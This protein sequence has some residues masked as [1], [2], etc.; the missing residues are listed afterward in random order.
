[1]K[2][3]VALVSVISLLA[4]LRAE[5]AYALS[6]TL[7]DAVTT[8][9]LAADSP[10][11]VVQVGGSGLCEVQIWS[12]AG[13][14]NTTVTIYSSIAATGTGPGTS[15]DAPTIL[16]QVFN[17]TTN[18]PDNYIYGACPN[19]IMGEINPLGNGAVTVKFR[20]KS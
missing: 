7:F 6:V 10:N 14:S 15:L 3:L 18:N 13:S 1:M 4:L 9:T 19:Y 16:V 20:T 2:K 11:G 8:A 17:P 12:A 5:P